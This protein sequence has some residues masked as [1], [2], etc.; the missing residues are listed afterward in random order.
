[1]E[2]TLLYPHMVRSRTDVHCDPAWRDGRG[3][4]PW[5]MSLM[6]AFIHFMKRRTISS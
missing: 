2:G 1:M 3:R 5:E 4:H 6:R